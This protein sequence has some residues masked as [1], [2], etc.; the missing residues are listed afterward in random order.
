MQLVPRLSCIGEMFLLLHLMFMPIRDDKVMWKGN[1]YDGYIVRI[2]IVPK[3]PVAEVLT[4]YH[5][6]KVSKKGL[7]PKLNTQVHSTKSFH[8][9]PFQRGKATTHW[10]S[11]ERNLV[12]TVVILPL[13][14]FLQI[15]YCFWKTQM[16]YIY[17]RFLFFRS[18]L[19]SSLPTMTCCTCA[20]LY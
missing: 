15:L 17:I 16:V 4:F 10:K 6:A 11:L 5:T 13:H 18:Y 3:T 20:G 9:K 14:N 12:R 19:P 7:N 2:H 8:H 1:S